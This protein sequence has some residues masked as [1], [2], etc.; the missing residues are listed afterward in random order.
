MIVAL[1]GVHLTL[2]VSLFLF[3]LGPRLTQVSVLQYG[4]INTIDVP[5]DVAQEKAHLL[6]LV[7]LIQREGGPSQIGNAGTT[8]YV[9]N[10]PSGPDS[11]LKGLSDLVPSFLLWVARSYLVLCISFQF[12]QMLFR[13][14][15]VCLL[16]SPR[17]SF[18]AN[19]HRV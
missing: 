13:V 10:L 6:S 18:K 11:W 15:T 12:H 1:P 9:W 16:N 5:W 19:A 14:I 2:N 8:S 7:D 17:V 4:R 3:L